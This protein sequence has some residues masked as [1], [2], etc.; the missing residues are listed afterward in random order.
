MAIENREVA[1]M[2]EQIGPGNIKAIMKTRPIADKDENK[3]KQNREKP[4]E[5]PP[6]KN[7]ENSHLGVN[8]D[9]QC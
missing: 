2:V 9:E 5:D 6:P 4:T 8:I 3:S 7:R 1:K